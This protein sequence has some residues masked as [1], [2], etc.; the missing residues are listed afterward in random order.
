MHNFINTTPKF[1][2]PHLGLDKLLLVFIVEL[3][4]H[5]LHLS[6]E[7]SYF[8]I[9]FVVLLLELRFEYLHLR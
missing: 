7:L 9:F 6:R 4:N 8:N 1:F 5:A 3:L 2:F